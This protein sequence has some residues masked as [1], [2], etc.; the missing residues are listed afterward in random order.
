M[1]IFIA[2]GAGRQPFL[3]ELFM[4]EIDTAFLEKFMFWVLKMSVPFDSLIH[5]AKFILRKSSTFCLK[6]Y[7]QGCTL[8]LMAK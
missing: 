6:I 1:I 2:E 3:Y 5:L 4:V 8:I 7:V